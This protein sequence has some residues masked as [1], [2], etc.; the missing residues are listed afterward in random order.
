VRVARDAG[1]DEYF[2]KPLDSPRLVR[3]LHGRA[4]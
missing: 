4:A 2:V 3:V 1:F